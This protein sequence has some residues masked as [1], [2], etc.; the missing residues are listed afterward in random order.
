[1]TNSGSLMRLHQSAL[2]DGSQYAQEPGSKIGSVLCSIRGNKFLQRTVCCK[3]LFPEKL[4]RASL[5]SVSKLYTWSL[6]LWTQCVSYARWDIQPIP[7]V[8][9]DAMKQRFRR[10][11]VEVVEYPREH[12][13]RIARTTKRAPISVFENV[14]P[15]PE[16]RKVKSDTINQCASYAA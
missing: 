12:N 9:M 15:K 16:T 2:P 3:N 10:A 14:D 13:W 5:L 7:I 4:H 6:K 11:C 1:M 8:T